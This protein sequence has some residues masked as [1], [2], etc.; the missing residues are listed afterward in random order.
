MALY[1]A[2]RVEIL[3]PGAPLWEFLYAVCCRLPAPCCH[4][5]IN[6]ILYVYICIYIYI[7]LCIESFLEFP[8]GI[9]LNRFWL[10]VAVSEVL[11]Q[12]NIR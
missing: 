5:N 12:Y 2:F 4:T 8:A 11:I 1:V 9:I 7:Y 3:G 6:E 10:Q